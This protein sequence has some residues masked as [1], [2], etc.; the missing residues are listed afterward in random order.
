[1]PIEVTLPKD[2]VDTTLFVDLLD[3]ILPAGVTYRIIRKDAKEFSLTDNNGILVGLR[4][5]KCYNFVDDFEINGNGMSDLFI[6]D[7]A[8]AVKKYE[9]A[10]NYRDAIDE[11]GVDAN[12]GLYSNSVV[13]KFVAATKSNG[14]L[15]YPEVEELSGTLLASDGATLL[16]SDGNYL[17]VD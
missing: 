2:L 6:I 5:S 10:A 7:P 12:V 15:T 9:F 4:D 13:A 8:D 16:D 3:Y 11:I 14:E 1:M 17:L